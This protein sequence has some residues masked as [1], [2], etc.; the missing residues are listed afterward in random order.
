MTTAR[1]HRPALLVGFLLLVGGVAFLAS[2][3]RPGSWYDTLAKPPWTPPDWV[4]APAW[5]VLYVAIAVAG[6]LIFTRPATAAD[7]EPS[8]AGGRP[9]AADRLLWSLQLLLNALW[10]WLFFGL[11]RTGVALADLTALVICLSAL[12]FHLAG[13]QRASFWL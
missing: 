5:S 13:R 9:A 3:F 7:G 2:R 12:L 11:H 4:F 8:A 10:S 6:W 1:H